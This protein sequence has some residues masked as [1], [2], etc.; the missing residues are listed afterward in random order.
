[1]FIFYKAIIPGGAGG[2][3][4]ATPVQVGGYVRKDGTF[5]DPHQATRH[6]RH[7][8][9]QPDLFSARPHV[10][11]P[12]PNVTTPPAAPQET[13]VSSPPNVTT[14][15]EN[16]TPPA[17]P[18][19]NKAVAD[20]AA[21]ESVKRTAQAA[22][23]RAL[24][25]ADMEAAEADLGRDR[26]TNTHRRARMAAGAIENAN[27]RAQMAET[28][29]N[30]ADAI[31]YGEAKHLAGITSR[32]A[33]EALDYRLRQAMYAN[34]RKNNVSWGMRDQERAPTT[35]DIRIAALPKLE[36]HPRA[37]RDIARALEKKNPAAARLAAR[38]DTGSDPD[39]SRP[40]PDDVAQKIV[41]AL[42]AAKER[43]GW[44]L[45]DQV[46][47]ANR[48]ARIGVT[49]DLQLRQALAEY[50][51]Y[52]AGAR[53]EDPIKKAE[54]ELVG[55]Q[56]IDFFPT[57]PALVDQLI[58]EAGIKP[59][60]KVL[61][62]SAG[63]GDIADAL[64]R[65]GAQVDA[66]E[67]GGPPR[68]ILEAKGHNVVGGDFDTYEAPAGGY[69]RVVMNPPFSRDAEHVRR[70][71]DMLA[72]GGRVVAIVSRGLAQRSDR[73]AAGFREWVGEHGGVMTDLPEGSFKSAF[74][75]TGV[76]TI[77]V[78]LD[79]DSAAPAVAGPTVKPD[80]QVAPAAE[81]GPKEGDTKTEGGVTYRLEGGRWH[82][83]DPEP[84]A[85]PE[86][87]AG[88]APPQEMHPK[89]ATLD[90]AISQASEG[91]EPFTAEAVAELMGGYADDVLDQL[92]ARPDDFAL[93][94]DGRWQRAADYAARPDRAGE[95]SRLS[96]AIAGDHPQEHRSR[97]KRQLRRLAD[98]MADQ[99]PS[100]AD[101][102]PPA[103][104]PSEPMDDMDP[105]SPNYRYRDTGHIA[106]SRKELA[107]ESI[108][109]AARRGDRVRATDVDWS[110]LEQNPREAK[111]LIT[112]ANVFGDVDWQGM[113]AAGVEP[114]AGFLV[115]RIYASVG[116]APADD[117][118]EGRRDYAVAI[119]SL[120]DRAEQ[121]RSVADVANLLDEIGKERDGLSLNPAEQAAYDKLTAAYS[122][123][124]EK[125][126]AIA[127]GEQELSK[128]WHRSSAHHSK[129]KW[130]AEKKERRKWKVTDAEREA[131]ADA[132]A[133]AEKARL[134]MMAYQDANGTMAITT[135]TKEGGG[136]NTTFHYPYREKADKI[137]TLRRG[138][139]MAVVQRNQRDNPMTRA[140]KSLGSGFN[141]VVDYRKSKGSDAF[142]KHMATAKAGRI[143][144]WDWA[145]KGR[146]VK[147]ATKRST[148]FQLRVADQHERIGGRP[149]TAESTAA[150]KDTFGL[151]DVQSGHWVLED[152]NSAKFH[153][154]NAAGAFA[155]LADLLGVPDHQVAMSSRLAMA[156]GA[157]GQGSR[158]GVAHYEPVHRVIN[159]T[160]MA[161]GGSL[162]HE[163]FHFLD[164]VLGE[165]ISGQ[166]TSAE[167]YLT[168]GAGDDRLPPEVRSGVRDLVKAM[169]EGPHRQVE[170][171]AYTQAEARWASSN[172]TG[173]YGSA[174]G[175]IRKAGDMQNA[176][177]MIENLYASGSFGAVGTAKAKKRFQDWR[178]IALIYHAEKERQ[179]AGT[180]EDAPRE[181]RFFYGPGMS[182]FHKDAVDM[183]EGVSAKYWSSPK[184]MAARA[185]SAWAQDKLE[186]AGRRNT[187]LVSMADNEA[188]KA[189]GMP[190]RPFPENEERARI[191]AAFDRFVATIR[192]RGDLAKALA[193]L[194][195]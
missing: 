181:A 169:M 168:E 143:R 56:G 4:F 20:A 102:A 109:Q 129:L 25:D 124:W 59:G 38:F 146:E 148:R 175:A 180:P 61:E 137:A 88:D 157:R 81:E 3:L 106:G 89:A 15:P 123:E 101:P 95:V 12:A 28:M 160:K 188:Y 51:T 69:D 71:F 149:V 64:R 58:A 57:P 35:D 96:E 189:M 140:W 125:V 104:A 76:A 53:S 191:V 47:E 134:A 85:Q 144:D 72:P 158:T 190:H 36:L 192:D 83:A 37:A 98:A 161:G 29:K 73:R 150:L 147:G 186:A 108:R 9:A 27:K 30:L 115:S 176:V 130:D 11:P 119:D 163:W 136:S 65:A 151:R 2:D 82:R 187:Y 122:E 91:G 80:L 145:E 170:K 173:G 184:E 155:D 118:A 193:L 60:M 34:D 77:L 24:A 67:L 131:I 185:F 44:H 183:D 135:T 39:T 26:N 194:A 6:K 41:S 55:F 162:A 139:M 14:P 7:Q 126:R 48:L 97:W 32:A 33:V 70:A 152:Q 178:K 165:A 117:S 1:M 45:Q 63:K 100:S 172:A 74:R 50:V 21:R 93:T 10:T 90:E 40:V 46:K 107:A 121:C 75:P 116:A 8:A 159:I 127:N 167:D 133:E 103:E 66:V 177:D 179:A 42:V 17:P 171:L 142:G 16:V 13:A 195:A 166:P 110:E 31:E 111:A 87:P 94:T 18:A 43:E 5:V 138:F 49:T 164:N 132:A 120:R 112:K 68:A 174:A 114:G 23:L 128:A 99:V 92:H 154:E 105:A 54:R 86:A 141:A 78:V 84:E 19:E 62:P 52:R 156:F 113:Q 153:V 79:K 182:M 22:K